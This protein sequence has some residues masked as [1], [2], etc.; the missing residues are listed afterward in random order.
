MFLQKII[1]VMNNIF[2]TNATLLEI[3]VES[4]SMK[5]LYFNGYKCLM[6]YQ[7]MHNIKYL[8]CFHWANYIL[9]TLPYQNTSDESLE[10]IVYY[11]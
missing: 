11:F 1:N 7:I 8:P 6:Y 9:F 10:Y 2:I 5:Y 4:F 3:F